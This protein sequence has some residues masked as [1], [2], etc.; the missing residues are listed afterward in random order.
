MFAI[1]TRPASQHE[2]TRTRRARPRAASRAAE[3]YPDSAYLRRWTAHQAARYH[4]LLLTVA[5]A[6]RPVR[7]D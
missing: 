1:S 4:D 5:A 6:P 7:N 2:V 3:V